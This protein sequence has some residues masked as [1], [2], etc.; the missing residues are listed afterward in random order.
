M[1]RCR[2]FW[3]RGLPLALAI[4]GVPLLTCLVVFGEELYWR[5]Q[6]RRIVP[7][8]TYEQVRDRLRPEFEAVARDG[9]VRQAMD[10]VVVYCPVSSLWEVG[11]DFERA[12][13]GGFI[14]REKSMQQMAVPLQMQSPPLLYFPV[15]AAGEAGSSR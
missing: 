6:L 9:Y 2:R 7:G 12:G 5:W 14:L 4:V 11:L 1:L 15:L 8:M 13:N 3:L 10:R